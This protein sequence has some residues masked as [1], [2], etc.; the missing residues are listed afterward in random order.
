[1]WNSTATAEAGGTPAG[2]VTPGGSVT[3]GG[4]A[5]VTVTGTVSPFNEHVVVEGDTLLGI[6][7][8]NLAPGDDLVK[9]AQAIASLNGLN[10]DNPELRVGATLQLPKPHQRRCRRQTRSR[11]PALRCGEVRSSISSCLRSTSSC[12]R[13]S[14]PAARAAART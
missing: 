8:A 10:Y 6:A 9:F 13:S 11:P 1:M 7:Q 12:C 5:S 14:S 3:P 2:T 4:T